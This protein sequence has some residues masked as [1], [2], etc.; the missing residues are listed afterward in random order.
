MRDLADAISDAT[1]SIEYIDGPDRLLIP[2]D[3]IASRIK[4]PMDCVAAKLLALFTIA[5]FSLIKILQALSSLLCVVAQRSSNQSIPNPKVK[6]RKRKR[7]P[8]SR[9]ARNH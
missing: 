6:R 1:Y 4:K 5:C 3:Y 2:Y 9:L 7:S 8:C